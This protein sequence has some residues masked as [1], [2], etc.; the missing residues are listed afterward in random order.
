MP[1]ARASAGALPLTDSAPY[2][3]ALEPA[4]ETPAC[5]HDNQRTPQP[6]KG[7][8]TLRIGKG[9]AKES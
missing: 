4:P 7:K 9:N 5:A 1:A 6:M 2:P 8:L 3:D